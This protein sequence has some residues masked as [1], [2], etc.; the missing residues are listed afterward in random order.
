M[1]SWPGR[2]T[3]LIP[4][5]RSDALTHP[6]GRNLDRIERRRPVGTPPRQYAAG[7]QDAQACRARMAQIAYFQNAKLIDQ[8]TRK[9]VRPGAANSLDILDSG[10]SQV[11]RKVVVRHHP[12]HSQFSLSLFAFTV[13]FVSGR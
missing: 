2:P 5:L 7:C 11:L 13:P 1:R 10:P 12:R 4:F 3:D 9:F 6:L 8:G